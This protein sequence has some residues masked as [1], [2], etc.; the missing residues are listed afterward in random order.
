METLDISSFYEKMGFTGSPFSIT[1]DTD[2]FF[3]GS[4]HISA[5]EHLKYGLLSGG[6]T[7][8]TGEVGLGKTLLCRQL[9][10]SM[11]GKVRTVYI[12]NPYPTYDDLL[13]G[14]YYDLTGRRAVS[15]SFEELHYLINSA[16]MEIARNGSKVAI[17]LDEAHRY[18][19]ETLEG[20]R[21]LSNLE[22]EK[23]KLVRLILVGQPELERCVSTVEMRPLAQ[24]ISVR[25]KLRPFT[26]GETMRYINHRMTV[27]N[28]K[29]GFCF[30]L[31]SLFTAHKMSGGVPRRINQICDR[32]MMAAFSRGRAKVTAAMLYRAAVEIAR[33]GGD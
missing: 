20:L 4:R 29:G 32:A 21:L 12:F 3:P 10:K 15:S 1:P 26:L 33:G 14:I 7:M 24:R 9:L 17:L 27:A 16:I 23:E 18:S 2:F 22:T 30:S 28:G 25:Y 19:M 13:K 11:P 8:L 6:F 5:L 31:P